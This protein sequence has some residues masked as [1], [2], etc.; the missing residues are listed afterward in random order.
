MNIQMLTEVYTL[1]VLNNKR[2]I[3]SC[4]FKKN[5]SQLSH[6]ILSFQ[7]MKYT[8]KSLD[9]RNTFFFFPPDMQHLL[10]QFH[11]TLSKNIFNETRMDLITK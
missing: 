8:R 2:Q 1:N 5:Y 4:K 7:N 9:I 3:V 6:S 11:T 10:L